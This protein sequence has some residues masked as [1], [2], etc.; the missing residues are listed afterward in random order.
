MKL[1]LH[2]LLPS[3]WQSQMGAELG[4]VLQRACSFLMVLIRAALLKVYAK[5]RF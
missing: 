3:L 2:L 1:S 5:T 4:L